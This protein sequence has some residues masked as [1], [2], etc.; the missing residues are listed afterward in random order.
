[1]KGLN[2]FIRLTAQIGQKLATSRSKQFKWV[3]KWFKQ[4]YFL[5]T[6]STKKNFFL[7][8]LKRTCAMDL[9]LERERENTG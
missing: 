9:F 2:F 4:G 7:L 1:M 3:K 6:R 8:S 5:E